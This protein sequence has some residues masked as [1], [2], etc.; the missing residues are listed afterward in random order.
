MVYDVNT[1]RFRFEGTERPV[2]GR[3]E[4]PAREVQGG[5]GGVEPR[6]EQNQSDS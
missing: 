4:E 1:R 5:P 2:R 3:W 6:A